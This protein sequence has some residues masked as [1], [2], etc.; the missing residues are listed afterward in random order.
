MKRLSILIM[1]VAV[2]AL[3]S[4]SSL[5]KA[6][7]GGDAAALT[8]QQCA[9]ATNA[10]YKTYK[11]TGKIALTDANNVSNILVVVTSYNQL[12][13]H[14][15]DA[16]YRKSFTKG[17]IAAGT[18]LITANNGEAFTNALLNASGLSGVNAANV[19]QKVQTASTIITLFNALK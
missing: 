13:S 18:G 12:K 9:V 6:V 2:L 7:S 14:K 15:G 8:G 10:L 3:A 19:Q 4:C 5:Q 17:A 11:S 1:S 16:N